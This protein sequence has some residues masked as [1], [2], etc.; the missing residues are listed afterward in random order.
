MTSGRADILE[1]ILAV[2]R[3]EIAALKVMALADAPAR[4]HRSLRAA[5]HRSPDQ[6]MRVLAEVKRASPSA[7]P[8]RADADPV[9]IARE[10]ADAGAA[11]IS[12]LT[13]QQF[14]DGDIAFLQP[15][16]DAVD[17]PILRKDF[18][19]DP[20]Q[21][22]E[23]AAHGA[24]AVLLIVAALSSSE[25]EEMMAAV[26][27]HKLEV[28][29]EV[30][31]MDELD[32]ALSLS[33]P[34]TVIGVNHRDLRTFTIDMT[35]TEQVAKRVPSNIVLVAESGIRTADDVRRM[36]DAGAHAVLVG[37]HLMRAPS[38]GAALRE[39]LA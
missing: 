39:L 21:V 35:L 25:L 23:A 31:D 17:V 22:Q 6:P 36:R 12:V 2:K 18:L 8:I 3:D 13:D 27:E 4:G 32:T 30:H 1:K 38:P 7:G 20:L 28:L 19:I 29:V 14:F 10:Y 9:A 16:H 37:E 11:A 34:P 33:R 15:C 5:L 24:D 26:H